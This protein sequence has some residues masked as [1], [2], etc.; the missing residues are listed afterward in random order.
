M[1]S[2]MC[3][4]CVSV[5]PYLCNA[6]EHSLYVF[7]TFIAGNT[8]F[9]EFS[10][11]V[12]LDD[13]QLFY[14]DSDV[15]KLIYRNYKPDHEATIQK[16][17]MLIFD[18]QYIDMKNWVLVLVKQFNVTNGVN[19]QQRLAGCELFDKDSPGMLR[20]WEAFNGVGQGELLFNSQ[21]NTLTLPALFTNLW[22][23]FKKNHVQWLY[24][25]VYSPVCIKALKDLLHEN[26]NQI[27]KKVKPRVRL[28]QKAPTHSGGALLTCL[29]TGFYP[30]H[31]NLTM[32][33]DGQP[34]TE[35]RVIGG[36]VLPNGDG[37]YQMRKRLEVSAEEMREKHNYTCTVMHLS[38]ANKIDISM[39][40]RLPVDASTMTVVVMVLGLVVVCVIV[41]VTVFLVY[42]R[43]RNGAKKS[44]MV[45]YTSVCRNVQSEAS[46]DT[47]TTN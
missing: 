24:A 41:P 34:V 33:R 11:V 26:R 28:L 45:T 12:M 32:L 13:V 8:P 42:R 15:K 43:K 46:S 1:K 6:G 23:T 2:L 30:R 10:A 40:I 27:R 5:L 4:C 9:P 36:E 18:H 3:L 35:E 47:T 37:I 20:S 22:D 29:A 14:Y 17:L 21:L 7:S 19:V 44:P 38:L 31:I 25:N 16:D 39:E